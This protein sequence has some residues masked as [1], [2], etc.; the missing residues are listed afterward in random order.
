MPTS[1]TSAPA[2]VTMTPASVPLNTTP[3]RTSVFPDLR[4]MSAR[5]AVRV[6]ARMGVTPRIHGAGVVIEQEP[7][8]GSPIDGQT[9][10]AIWLERA[11]SGTAQP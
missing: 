1:G 2:I 5:D 3:E 10:C 9:A 11:P 4:G 8:P 7:Q 6:L